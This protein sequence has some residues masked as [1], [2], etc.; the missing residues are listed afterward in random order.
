MKCDISLQNGIIEITFANKRFHLLTEEKPIN[1]DFA[2]WL[3]ILY[4]MVY[5]FDIEIDMPLTTDTLFN[6]DLMQ[7]YLKRYLHLHECKIRS[8]IIEPSRTTTGTIMPFSGG[9]DSC[10]TLFY[11]HLELHR[12]IDRALIVQGLD[13]FDDREYELLKQRCGRILDSVNVTPIFLSTNYRSVMQQFINWELQSD[14]VLTG[15]LHIFDAKFA[16]GLISGEGDGGI[17]SIADCFKTP[18]LNEQMFLL[19]SNNYMQIRAFEGAFH[20][21]AQKIHFIAHEQAALKN[22]R[23]CWARNSHDN[24]GHCRKCIITEL[25]FLASIGKIPEAF[26]DA[27]TPMDVARLMQQVKE[28]TQTHPDSTAIIVPRKI[29]EIIEIARQT[30]HLPELHNFLPI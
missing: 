3:I 16:L 13:L 5:H 9:V 17:L 12:P 1:G 4:A 23:V 18:F 7:Q 24:C 28:D 19:F 20:N 10:F 2:L 27:M 21:K 29:Q 22:V 8:P 15:L 30:G 14:F 25:A 11:N 26:P 6:I